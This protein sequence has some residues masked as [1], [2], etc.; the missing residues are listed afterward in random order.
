MLLVI[1]R[2]GDRMQ[3]TSNDRLRFVRL[4]PD[5]GV[6]TLPTL[7]HIGIAPEEINCPGP[8]TEQLRHPGVVI[9]RFRQ[10]A[11]GAILCRSDTA[12]GVREMRIERLS[13]VPFGGKR[14]LL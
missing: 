6:Q 5:N 1:G 4:G 14:L 8:E 13:A 2:I 11:V 7:A 12:G 10:M 3:M 9:I